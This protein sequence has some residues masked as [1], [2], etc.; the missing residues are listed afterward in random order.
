[1]KKK[2]ILLVEDDPDISESLEI[3]LKLKNYEV[4]KLFSGQGVRDFVETR[5]PDLVIMDVMMPPPDG[6]E[7]CRQLKSDERTRCVPVILLSARTQQAEIE[8]GFNA[9]ADRYMPKPFVN[10]ELLSAV[11]ILLERP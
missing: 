6:Y 5:N 1:M 9:G 2:N 7:V 3:T 11:E 4:S 10:E 8:Q